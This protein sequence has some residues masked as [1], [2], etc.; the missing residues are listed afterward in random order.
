MP[1]FA[2]KIVISVFGSLGDLHPMI[3]LGQGL[4]ARGHQVVLA[5]SRIY[6]EKIEGEGLGF[7][8]LRPEHDYDQRIVD[9]L[10]HRMRGPETLI[11]KYVLPYVRDSFHDLRRALEK[12][13]LLINAPMC[14]V[15]PTVAEVLGLP[16]V[17]AQL[18]PFGYF[19]VYD[20]PVL[21]QWPI[22]ERWHNRG[23]LFWRTLFGL[24]KIIG[25][26]WPQSVYRLRKESGLPK[27]KNP[28]FEGFSPY[29]NL[30]LFSGRFAAPQPDWPPNT[31][32]TGFLFHD[33]MRPGEPEALPPPI[34]AFLSAGEP[35]VVFTLGSSVVRT[36][37]SFFKTS[38]Q[39][40]SALNC[41]AIFLAG[42]QQ[43]P[44]PLT[45]RMLWWDW[46]PYS[47]LFPHAAVVVHQ[48]GIGTCAQAMRAGKPTLVVPH[49]FDQPDNA[50][51]L[52]RL[53][54][55]RTIYPEAYTEA[56]VVRELSTLLSDPAYAQKAVLLGQAIRAEDG[57]NAACDHIEATLKRHKG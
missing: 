47:A 17:H 42:E 15:G 34:Q 41:R 53:G 3:A 26:T 46:A 45:E 22:T 13:D 36:S 39:A 29:L 55:S 33:R 8:H 35:P 48:G 12:A 10:F 6:Q 18:Q 40:A 2:K 37:T 11:K 25:D 31:Y 50:A 5:A 57:L 43:P 30:A 16:W 38:I 23:P 56:Q 27:G 24:L 1:D 19:S 20:P 28:I 44:L 9:E 32:A 7:A 51:R 14:Y 21:Q 49:G 54:V 52:R 4:Q